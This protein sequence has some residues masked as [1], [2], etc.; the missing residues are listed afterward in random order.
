MELKRNT[1]LALKPCKFISVNFTENTKN[2]KVL[3]QFSNDAYL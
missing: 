1:T 3:F 2:K